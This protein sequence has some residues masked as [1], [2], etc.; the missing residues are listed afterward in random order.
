MKFTN[1][2]IRSWKPL[3]SFLL[4]LQLLTGCAKI[5]QAPEPV[6]SLPMDEL[7]TAAEPAATEE[8][9]TETTEPQAELESLTSATELPDVENPTS[10]A[11]TEIHIEA[12]TEPETEAHMAQNPTETKPADPK[13]TGPKP[14]EPTPTEPKPTEPTPTEPRPTEP[15]P[16]EP[17]PTAPP[18][19]QP[20]HTHSYT[21]KV[22]AATC[23]ANGYTEHTC[24]CGDSY[25]DSYTDPI[26]HSYKDTVV[27]PTTSSQGYTEHTCTRCG[28]SYRDSYTDKLQ[29]AIDLQEVIEYGLAY[30]QSLGYTVDRSMTLADS[31]YYPGYLSN[32]KYFSETQD[33]L[34]QMACGL[35]KG[36]T[37]ELIAGGDTIP[38]F[39]CNIY[40]SYDKDYPGEYY[41]VFLYG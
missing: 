34:K 21:S 24:S 1:P 35:V 29:E 23:T 27:S 4:S 22:I 8:P 26:G 9:G 5:S 25:R 38:G 28:D 6:S 31:S 3:L 33:E 14:T 16:T 13:P 20:V 11:P 10:E 12:P 18:E 15:K 7:S 32:T 2:L 39:R 40:A 37:D 36:T 17:E 30:A 41:I 19:T